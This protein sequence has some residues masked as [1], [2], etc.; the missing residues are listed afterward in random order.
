MTKLFIK[1]IKYGFLICLLI[2]IKN[3][4]SESGVD[5]PVDNKILT[6]MRSPELID[7]NDPLIQDN[8]Y[9]S[10]DSD[11]PIFSEQME[12]LK[13]QERQQNIKNLHQKNQP[14][15]AE[16][17]KKSLEQAGKLEQ[18][19]LPTD[20]ELLD[21]APKNNADTNKIERRELM[22]PAY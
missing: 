1:L 10:S 5:S 6:D 22:Q 20:Q 13:N 17:Y 9:L 2:F 21:N 8:E 11:L 3:I 19:A 15:S 12:M 16:S 14:N 4:Y 18:G 7:I